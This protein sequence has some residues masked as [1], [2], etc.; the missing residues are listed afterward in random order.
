[1]QIVA[2][3]GRFGPRDLAS[4][5]DEAAGDGRATIH[6]QSHREGGGVPAAGGE[7]GKERLGGGILI[8]MKGLRVE[9]FREPFDLFGIQSDATGW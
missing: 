1:M 8:E 5:A 3:T 6:E 2:G 9:L 7:A 4:R